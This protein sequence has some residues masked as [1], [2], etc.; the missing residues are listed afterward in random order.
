MGTDFFF[1]SKKFTRYLTRALRQYTELHTNFMNWKFNKL[2]RL[3]ILVQKLFLVLLWLVIIAIWLGQNH[4]AENDKIWT[5][6]ICFKGVGVDNWALFTH[7]QVKFMSNLAS[8]IFF[9]KYVVQHLR[10]LP[11]LFRASD[12]STYAPKMVFSRR[13]LKH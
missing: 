6:K 13:P 10:T 2:T 4:K 5:W 8:E 12:T 7:F 3:Y 11:V 9:S 1:L